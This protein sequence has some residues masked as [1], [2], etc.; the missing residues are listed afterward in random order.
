MKKRLQN[1]SKDYCLDSY[2][3][4]SIET[5]Y[6]SLYGCMPSLYA[7][8]YHPEVLFETDKNGVN[9]I[10]KKHFQKF[11]LGKIT[12]E[13]IL[14]FYDG[15]DKEIA[16][17]FGTFCVDVSTDSRK[18]GKN[19]LIT[20]YSSVYHCGNY[21]NTSI[22]FII[23][24]Y[25]AIVT[26]DEDGVS[27]MHD[28]MG[29]IDVKQIAQEIVDK[30]PRKENEKSEKPHINL[31]TVTSD[32]YK[33]V[34]AEINNID[35]DID[36]NYNDDFKDAHKA[37]DDFISSEERHSG[38]I[39]LSGKPGTGKTYYIR[40]LVATHNNIKFFTI[41]ASV[42]VNLGS[43]EFVEFLMRNKNS[44]FI[45]EDCDQVI[46]SREDETFVNAVS[47]IL[48]MTD[49]L[50]GDILNIKLICTFNMKST[51]IDKALLRKGRCHYKYE[52]KA[53]TKEKT[54]ALAKKL[55]IEN[56]IDESMTLA[57]IFNYNLDNN[58][59]ET[60][61]NGGKKKIGF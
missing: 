2:G 8:R 41:P 6:I 3:N 46:K 10:T 18:T 17:I 16:E 50:M 48:N 61:K 35:V 60:T 54:N 37:I 31:V 4:V 39:L 5:L 49:G 58:I 13:Y 51:D 26:I 59:N 53:L 40:H 27:V 19:N 28:F 24:N 47:N 45:L 7:Y 11:D 36:S 55:G 1:V 34:E 21:L 42:A 20:D 52:F 29:S 9:R 23:D 14:N 44:V 33:S 12:K 38:L 43:P 56:D 32:G 57:E 25:K 30:F 22:S 15:T